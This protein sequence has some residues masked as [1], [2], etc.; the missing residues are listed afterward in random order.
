MPQSVSA[1]QRHGGRTALPSQR[2]QPNHSSSVSQPDIPDESTAMGDATEQGR[3]RKREA[4][5]T[6][7]L[8]QENEQASGS[9]DFRT[10]I[11]RSIQDGRRKRQ[12]AKLEEQFLEED[13]TEEVAEE[14]AENGAEE[15][16]SEQNSLE[17]GS[18]EA[19]VGRDGQNSDPVL[20]EANQN[21]PNATPPSTMSAQEKKWWAMNFEE[22]YKYAR[23]KNFGKTGKE[24]RK[25][26]RVKI[27]KWLCEKECITPYVAP[28]I[29]SV[30]AT[31]IIARPLV[32]STGAISHPEAILRTSDPAVQRLIDERQ[33]FY[34]QKSAADLLK[35]AMQRSYQLLKDSNGKLPSKSIRATSQWLAAWDVL[36]SPREKKWWLADGIDLVN[37]AKAMGYQG[38]SRKYDA[39]IWLR[40]TPEDAEVEVAEV[41]EPTPNKKREAKQPV[42]K[43]YAKG[44]RRVGYD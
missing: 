3:K 30:E 4:F 43:R 10:M 32:R 44:S 14:G 42:S 26:G 15:H 16:E 41:A 9:L 17:D 39:I 7:E 13:N 19:R 35:L 24:G 36:K 22:L 12:Q 20:D 38:P 8:A 40:Y 2:R 27:I 33:E 31:P 21:I 23:S 37:K 25:S 18:E 29:T 34:Q 11:E 28:I 5:E 1:R 6:P